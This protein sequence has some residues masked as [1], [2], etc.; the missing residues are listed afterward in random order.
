MDATT[1]TDEGGRIVRVTGLLG[2]LLEKPASAMQ[3]V[4]KD[5]RQWMQIVSLQTEGIPIGFSTYRRADL[6][7]RRP[8][9]VEFAENVGDIDLMPVGIPMGPRHFNILARPTGGF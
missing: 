8:V 4:G 3:P 7:G 2:R 5:V 9:W 6:T 1:P